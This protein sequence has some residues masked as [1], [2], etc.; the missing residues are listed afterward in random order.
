MLKTWKCQVVNFVEEQEPMMD[1]E[2]RDVSVA[3]H[4]G[5]S[6]RDLERVKE[7]CIGVGQSRGGKNAL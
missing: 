7:A 1:G 5:H 2:Q 3:E 4:A 6:K